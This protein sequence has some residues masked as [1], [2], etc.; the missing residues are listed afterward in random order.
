MGNK[1]MVQY[2]SYIKT[3]IDLLETS[4]SSIKIQDTI[5]YTL[6]GL[7]NSYQSFKMAICT[8]LSPLSL[9]DFHSQL[10]SEE[11]I[12]INE[13][14]LLESNSHLALIVNHSYGRGRWTPNVNNQGQSSSNCRRGQN[15]NIVC[16]IC[17]KLGH[18]ANSCWHQVNIQYSPQSKSTTKAFQATLPALGNTYL[19]YGLPHISQMMIINS[20]T[21]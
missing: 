6:N 7:P 16:Q 14:A 9:D 8:N 18:S 4:M 1:S 11:T 19:I 15:N 5:F 21:M 12:Q 13:H 17:E 2:L 20:N 10:C 3:K